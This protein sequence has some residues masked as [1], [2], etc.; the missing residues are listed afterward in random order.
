MRHCPV[1]KKFKRQLND[2]NVRSI[3]GVILVGIRIVILIV[4]VTD[5][6]N[7]YDKL[8]LLT[9]WSSNV[10][11]VMYCPC[12]IWCPSPTWLAVFK[13]DHRSTSEG[14]CRAVLSSARKAS[15]DRLHRRLD[16]VT[17]VDHTMELYNKQIKKRKE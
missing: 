5:E 14:C 17:D 12:T 2:G 9:S 7:Q 8:Q 16:C 15:S 10:C 13:G 4:I 1:V 11:E 6:G 3:E